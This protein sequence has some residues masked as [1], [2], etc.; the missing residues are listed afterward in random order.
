M[1]CEAYVPLYDLPDVSTLEIWT[2]SQLWAL[3]RAAVRDLAA[4]LDTSGQEI[5]GTCRELARAVALRQEWLR[6]MQAPAALPTA[7]VPV[8]EAA[9]RWLQVRREQQRDTADLCTMRALAARYA[10]QQARVQRILCR[11][12]DVAFPGWRE[13]RQP[14]TLNK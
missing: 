10:D 4:R 7:S 14:C 8:G 1:A 13:G 11:R 5:G 12:Y 3:P 2:D 6:W 9:E